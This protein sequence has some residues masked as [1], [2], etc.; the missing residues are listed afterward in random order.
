MSASLPARAKALRD[1]LLALDRLGANVEETGLLEDLRSDLA[2]H[3]AELSRALDERALL[4]ASGIETPEPPTLKTAR[5]Q[6]ATLLERFTSE[7]KAATLKRGNGWANLIK[8][9]KTAASDL[10]TAAGQSWKGYRQTVFTGEAPSL[11]K[12]RIALTP[13]NNAAFKTYELLHQAFLAEFEKLPVDKAAIDGVKT[14]AAKLTETAKDFDFD[15]PVDVKR[16]LEA[17]QTGGAKLELLT[18]AVLKWLEENNAVDNYRIV[19]RSPDGS[20]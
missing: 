14:L 5:K 6:A 10:G 9:I 11:V 19:P 8:S 4:I 17:I 20:R 16:F 1:R 3:A 12:G 15:V 2:P 7:R 13:T 18:D